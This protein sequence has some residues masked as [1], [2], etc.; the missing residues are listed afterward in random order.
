MYSFKKIALFIG[1][2]LPL[3]TAAPV[4][5]TATEIVPGKFIVTLKEGITARGVESH[6]EWA[7]DIHALSLSRRGLAGVEN[8][9]DIHDFHAYA[10]EFDEATIEEIKASPDVC[11]P[12]STFP[13]RYFTQVPLTQKQVAA[14]EP[15]Q[16]W[17]LFALTTQADA[18]SWGLGAIS[19]RAGAGE[20]DYIYD[21]SAGSGTFA[22]VVDS[23]INADH[24]TFGG[25]ASL[26][27][28]A[29]TGTTDTLGHG[30]H[31]AGT[32]A[33]STY[34]VAKSATVIAV[35]VFEGTS[36]TTSTILSGYD[37]A[38]NDIVSKSRQSK[39]AIS[40]SLGESFEGQGRC[41]G[42][43]MLLT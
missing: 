38:V 5:L 16:V 25:R 19:H 4:N 32:V 17:N 15:D 39:S 30:T 22:Y 26:G 27:F 40:L 13:Y 6:L 24:V 41:R 10:G 14:V 12:L 42:T 37:W 3:A 35:K 29:V 8:T 21:S 34:G 36:S 20:T 2:L 1:A 9:Y 31:V 28:T 23:G 18:P 33:S 43:G 7:R 11:S